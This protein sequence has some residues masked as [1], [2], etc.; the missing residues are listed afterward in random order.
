MN[1]LLLEGPTGRVGIATDPNS[2]SIADS[3]FRC[4]RAGLTRVTAVPRPTVPVATPGQLHAVAAAVAEERGP[5]LRRAHAS[6][7][8]TNPFGVIS[9]RWDGTPEI[10][11]LL[12]S[13]GFLRGADV[14]EE[15]Y[16]TSSVSTL[17]TREPMW[18]RGA[19]HF[20]AA[21]GALSTAGAEVTHPV[22]HRVVGSLH[23]VTAVDDDS[24]FAL[25]WVRELVHE[26]ERRMLGASASDEQLLMDAFLREVLDGRHP[27]VAINSRTILTNAAAARIVGVEEQSVLWEHAS[28]VTRGDAAGQDLLQVGRGLS[29]KASCRTVRDGDRV[30]GVVMKLRR[31]ARP[32]VAS[33][34]A[35]IDS[36][37]P[38]AGSGAKWREMCRRA[39]QS[40]RAPLL[41]VGER[42]V[43]KHAVARALSAHGSVAELDAHDAVSDSSDA[44]DWLDRVTH[45]AGARPENLL[46]RHVEVLDDRAAAGLDAILDAL[47]AGTR[48]IL[49][50]A[51]APGSEVPAEALFAR[52]LH[53][54]TVPPLRERM[55]DLVEIVKAVTAEVVGTGPEAR[56][57]QWMSDALQVL[58]RVEWTGNVGALESVVRSVL[59]GTATGYIGAGNLPPELLVRASG[60]RLSPLERVEANAILLALRDA[61][62]NKLI[63]AERLGIARS[64][65]YRKVRALGID[66]ST[67]TY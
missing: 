48:P 16:G 23:L 4:R 18:V 56:P 24:P 34:G 8:L 47:P 19:E 10:A 32:R 61:G 51:V 17:V 49:T 22:I 44:T 53:T 5:D 31:T 21:L 7:V 39:W 66:L 27:V 15:V 50:S 28:R 6:L 60:R 59:A 29:L 3:W 9:A 55:E 26:L 46:I 40:G 20:S 11:R 2:D 41:L 57:V 52:F 65:L 43:G 58:G 54:V 36:M 62:G 14:S 35:G 13:I 45:A 12:D 64:T 67:S 42:G 63:A 33:T 25:S 37:S 1:E 38:L 30:V